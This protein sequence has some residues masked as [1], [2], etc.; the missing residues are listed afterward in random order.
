MRECGKVNHVQAWLLLS[1]Q[2]TIPEHA[3]HTHTTSAQKAAQ[4]SLLLASCPKLI[5]T[6]PLWVWDGLM[7]N[8]N[9]IIRRAGRRF[10]IARWVGLPARN[11]FIRCSCPEMSAGCQVDTK[12]S[13]QILLEPIRQCSLAGA[14][15]RAA[16]TLSGKRCIWMHHSVRKCRA[17]HL[18][19]CDND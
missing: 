8:T 12:L 1:R 18:G 17:Q 9:H 11:A 4:E 6:R 2:H 16:H 5:Q 3:V 13:C 10:C 14:K 15:T 7:D 19:R